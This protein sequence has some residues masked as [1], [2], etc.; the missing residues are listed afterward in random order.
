MGA[1]LS[2][3]VGSVDSAGTRKPIVGAKVYLKPSRTDVT[4]LSTGVYVPWSVNQTSDPGYRDCWVAISNGSGIASFSGVPFTDTEMH[5]PKDASGNVIGPPIE[6]LLINPNGAS[7]S[8]V[9]SVVVYRGQLL[10]TMTLPSPVQIPDDVMTLATDAWQLTQ[11][12]YTA[13]PVGGGWQSGDLTFA[14]GITQQSIVFAPSYSAPP[15]VIVGNAYDKDGNT[16]NSGVAQDSSGNEMVS[17]SSATVQIAAGL[18][19]SVRVPYLVMG[20]QAQ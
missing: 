12:S 6:W 10:S 1:T 8:G 7:A 3:Y 18:T 14:P 16:S 13:N 20:V 15:R 5:R 4:F 11:Q 9:P 2:I 17:T 19:S